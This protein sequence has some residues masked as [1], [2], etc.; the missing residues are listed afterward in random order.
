MR[1]RVGE[2]LFSLA[3]AAGAPSLFVVGTGKNV[4]KTVAMR[5]V[6]EACVDHGVVA[7]LASIGRD[8]EAV[9]AGDAEL[10]PRLFLHPGT[11]IVTARQV[12]PRSPASELLERSELRTAAG[13]LLYARVRQPAH[14]ELVGPP[15]ASGLREA[16]GVLLRHAAF[17]VVDGAVDRIAALSGGNDAVVVSCGAAAASTQGEAVDGVRALVARLRI[18]P[19]ESGEA[20]RIGGALTPAMVAELLRVK[21]T[22]TIVLR[23]PTQFA[24]TGKAALYALERLSIRCE[25]PLNV[26]AVTIA[27]IARD[28]S[29]EPREFARS[30]ARATGLPTFD[31]YAAELAA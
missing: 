23:D 15:T 6:Y 24:L 13:M 22:R 14:F 3:R 26:I 5:A 28:R 16:V 18:P 27:S 4:G 1:A 31:V 2:S 30:V 8:G 29:F 21:E 17:A 19:Y 20:L 12:L 10:K 11:V 7:G 9:D 25:R